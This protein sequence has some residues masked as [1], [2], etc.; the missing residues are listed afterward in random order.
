MLGHFLPAEYL[1]LSPASRHGEKRKR[2]QYHA[3]PGTDAAKLSPVA[4][5]K[6]DRFNAR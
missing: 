3:S 6:G 5:L 1:R 2:D 4:I